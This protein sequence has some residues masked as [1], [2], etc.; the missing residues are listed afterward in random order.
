MTSIPFSRQCW[1]HLAA[2]ALSSAALLMP[3]AEAQAY[4]SL[5][6]FGDS[7]SDG[8]NVAL[9]IGQPNG[10]PQVISGNSYIPDYP[11]APS[12]RYSNGPV[13]AETFAQ[14]LGLP[15]LPSLAG[16]SNYAFAGARTSGADVPVPTLTTQT[17]AFLAQVQG[18]APA[19]A[20]YVI[21]E[22]GNDARDALAAIAGGADAT[23]TMQ[24]AATRYASDV[25]AIVDSL[26]DAGAQHFLVFNNV[27]LGRVPAVAAMGSD[28]AALAS[29][30]TASMNT[31][32]GQRL[33]GQSDITLLDTFSFIDRV[34]LDPQAFGFVNGSDAC[35]A[36]AQADCSG[37]VFWDGLHPTAAMHRVIADAALAAAVP[38]PQSALLLLAGGL[39]VITIRR[40]RLA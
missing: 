7:V 1:S 40:R 23:S 14:S 2:A 9:T 5:V 19:D 13:W 27:D 38:E 39:A 21:A 31:E 20:L 18:V 36:I 11:Y 37:Y 4:S 15:L 8:G 28:A 24:L 33:Q 6:V 29:T 32:L 35:G 30:L 17:A 12:G 25:G 10:V 3:V 26:R 22:V 34:T 16:G